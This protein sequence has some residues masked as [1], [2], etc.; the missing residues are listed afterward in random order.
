MSLRDG[1][2]K[3]SKSDA[4]D[5]SRINM[6]DDADAIAKK[7][8]KATS[9]PHLIPGPEVLGVL[10]PLYLWNDLAVMAFYRRQIQWR[11]IAS[12][13]PLLLIGL[14]LQMEWSLD[15]VKVILILILVLATNPTATHAM[16]K[17]TLHGGQ[18]PLVFEDDRTSGGE[19]TSKP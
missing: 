13:L 6:T 10:I 7:V 16:A 4:S 5:L 3:M 19:G 8:R 14:L 17:A 11:L 1:S 12:M 15:S 9:D 2:K 18:R